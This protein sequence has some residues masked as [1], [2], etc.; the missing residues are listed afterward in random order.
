ML[1]IG[2]RSCVVDGELRFHRQ[3]LPFLS[4]YE[5][6]RRLVLRQRIYPAGER[7]IATPVIA[8]T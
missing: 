6:S 5:P 8:T 4:K 1:D 7:L 3:H 2:C